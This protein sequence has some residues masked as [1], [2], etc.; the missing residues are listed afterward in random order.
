MIISTGSRVI[1][2]VV[3]YLLLTTLFSLLAWPLQ[4]AAGIDPVLISVVQFAP[5]LGALGTILAF[6]RSRRW[7]SRL[8]L[9]APGGASPRHMVTAMAVPAGILLLMLGLC[10]AAG[11]PV[12]ITG[13]GSTGP[14]VTALLIAQFVGACGEELGWRCWLQPTLRTRLGPVVAGMVIGMIWGVWH[15]QEFALG[16]LYVLGFLVST[17][18]M[19]VVLAILHESGR[20]P[21]L[22]T[23][24]GFHWIINI[25]LLIL[26]DEE[27]G[28]PGIELALG[29]AAALTAAAGVGIA[30]VAP[31]KT[32][33]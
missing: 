9:G 19:S 1:L 5:A 32:A 2:P 6:R 4:E 24:G 27:S 30:R 21:T 13:L 17:V 25:G 26:G 16:P 12:S 31:R 7:T 11:I 3:C 22:P 23:A 33:R 10:A 15:V 20:A 8:T 18:G 14:P 28:Q 29:L